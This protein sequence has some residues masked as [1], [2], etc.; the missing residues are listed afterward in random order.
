MKSD[1]PEWKKEIAEKVK[2]YGERKRRLMTP[3]APLKQDLDDSPQEK[4]EKKHVPVYVK[5]VEV[6]LPDPIPVYVKPPEVKVPDPVKEEIPEP[7]IIEPPAPVIVERHAPPIQE[8]KPAPP[9]SAAE[10]F[11]PPPAVEVW[12][13]DLDS[14]TQV[15]EPFDPMAEETA[16]TGAPYTSRRIVA[17]II[18]H[19]IL[20]VLMIVFMG[21]FS[22]LTGES[23]EAQMASP[24]RV[25]FPAFLI[26]HC[27]YFLYFFRATRQTPGMV[28]LSLELRDPGSSTIPFGKVLARWI[29]MIGLNVFN[30]IP[31][32]LGKNF[33]LM[34]LLSATEMR[35]F[36]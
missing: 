6:K 4:I 15:E 2:A 3:P 8:A 7:V 22:L 11:T 18:D 30:F 32:L 24:W 16:A 10:P 9:Q 20:I 14:F 13:E 25:T 35:S 5:P 19:T 21:A 36:K 1:S 34:D 17:G 12:T 27:I 28:F 33:L 26:C 31:V 29:A 23:M